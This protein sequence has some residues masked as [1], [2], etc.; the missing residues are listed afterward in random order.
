MP[1]A[2]SRNSPC[3]PDR[4][5]DRTAGDGDGAQVPGHRP[6][7]GLRTDVLAAGLAVCRS[8]QLPGGSLPKTL[9]FSSATPS[10]GKTVM[11]ASLGHLSPQR[12]AFSDH[13]IGAVAPTDLPL[14]Q[15]RRSGDPAV[16]ESDT[17]SLDTL[18]HHDLTVR[19]RRT[20]GRQLSPRSA[21]FIGSPR[22][23]QLIEALSQHYDSSS[24]IPRRRGLRDGTLSHRRGGLRR[25]LGPHARTR[26]SGVEADLRRP[27]AIAGIVLSRVVARQYR[28]Y[29]YRDPFYEYSRPI[30][31]TRR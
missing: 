26:R 31:A 13:C 4:G 23:A 18:I 1:K 17:V 9:L 21:H 15:S 5:D 27:G 30:N 3:R 19:R 24:S 8:D 14:Q 2:A 25:A 10:E 16:G 20:A 11:V 29:G 12:G 22:M 28:Q 7:D 6:H